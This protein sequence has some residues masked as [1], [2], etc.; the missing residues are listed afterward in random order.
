MACEIC[1]L[2][3]ASVEFQEQGYDHVLEEEERGHGAIES[4]IYYIAEN[5]VRGGLVEHSS[6]WQYSGNLASGYPD[7]DWRQNNFRVQ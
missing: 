5:P 1:G 4:L 3:K 6:D 2:G 7:L